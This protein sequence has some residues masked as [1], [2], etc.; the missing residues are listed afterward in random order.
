MRAYSQF[1]EE[2]LRDQNLIQRWFAAGLWT[3]EQNSS[4]QAQLAV[5]LRRTHYVL[6]GV[7][8][9]FTGV[10]VAATVGLL[11]V[12]VDASSAPAKHRQMF[13][14]LLASAAACF[15]LAWVIARLARLYRC[16]V[17]EALA[18]AGVLLLMIAFTLET[19]TFHGFLSVTLG[20]L[21]SLGVYFVFRFR[22]AIVASIL[23]VGLA[24]LFLPFEWRMQPVIVHISSILIFT[25]AF[26]IARAVAQSRRGEIVGDDCAAAQITAFGGI[27][28]VTNLMISSRWFGFAGISSGWFY[29]FTWALVWIIPAAALWLAIR[30]R[31]RLMII[32]SSVT[33]LV[34]LITNKAYLHWERQ[35]WDPILLGVVL[36]AT[37]IAL[38]RWL[39]AG[40]D[41]ERHGFTPERVLD[42]DRAFTL[43]TAVSLAI[44]N[45][46]VGS[47]SAA[48]NVSTTERINLQG[49]QSGGGGASGSF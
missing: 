11:M 28:F 30:E 44:P 9:L 15:A 19:W 7:L 27:Y 40:P 5:P 17:E 34:T 1:D 29:W 14:L 24:P 16:G 22:Y 46:T 4:L 10:I 38:R 3:A 32:A 31:D 39:V 2:C 20:A 13:G 23:L 6:R 26:F 42:D 45:P 33:M 47:V 41:G 36:M 48:G 43:A 25:T 18:A 21:A 37:A 8:F 12:V 49:G 35:T